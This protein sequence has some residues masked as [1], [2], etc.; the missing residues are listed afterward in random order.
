MVQRLHG[1]FNN[2][3]STHNSAIIIPPTPEDLTPPTTNAS[4]TSTG[5]SSQAPQ[6]EEYQETPS[7]RSASKRV[8]EATGVADNSDE[9]IGDESNEKAASS[10]ANTS[11]PVWPLSATHIPENDNNSIFP[12][13]PPIPLRDLL[14][15]MEPFDFD[16]FIEQDDA[17]AAELNFSQPDLVNPYIGNTA[18][19]TGTLGARQGISQGNM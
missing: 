12:P 6:R 8:A 9:P 14:G 18:E 19:V 11:S 2:Q 16:S 4:N 17:A 15:Q 1:A 7:L 10:T 13:A 5:R 3:F